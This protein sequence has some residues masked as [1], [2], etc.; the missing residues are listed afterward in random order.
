MG[1]FALGGGL[2]PRLGRLPLAASSCDSGRKP[3]LDLQREI[4]ECVFIHD[5]SLIQKI[6]GH[7]DRKKCLYSHLQGS[8][9]DFKLKRQDV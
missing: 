2:G 1:V 5:Q 9:S 4:I 6:L 3:G 7:L 8:F